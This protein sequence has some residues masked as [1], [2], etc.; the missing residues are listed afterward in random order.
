M[1]AVRK[2][3]KTMSVIIPTHETA[4]TDL[5]NIVLRLAKNPEEIIA[6]QKLRYTVFYQEFGII[7]PPHIAAAERD[8]DEYD[9]FAD[10]LVVIDES[11]IDPDKKIVGTYRLF[12]AAH[13][14]KN[15]PF[16]SSQEF[17]ISPL[18]NSGAQLLELGRSCVLP[19]YRTKYIMQKLWQGI[20]EYLSDHNIDLMFGCAS[21]QGTNP[22]A[23]ADQ[24]AYLKHFHSAPDDLCPV[25]TID[26]MDGISIKAKED[27]DARRIFSDLPPLIKGYLRVG[28]TIGKGAFLDKDFNCI[29]VC[30]VMPIHKM[31]SKYTKHYERKIQKDVVRDSDFSKKF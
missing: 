4:T 7:A 16:Y 8:Y 6:A 12:Q 3:K 30:I 18:I 14:P 19:E 27:L 9:N 23:I 13:L 20:A 22:E 21:F 31:S 28:A 10:H 15:I 24:L 1:S 11:Q 5:A 25:A 2:E 17:N 29:D 26:C